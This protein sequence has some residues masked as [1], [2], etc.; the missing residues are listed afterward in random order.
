MATQYR[1]EESIKLWAEDD[2]PRE[3][4]I[5][6]GSSAL[7]DA[8]LLAI[9]L[10]SGSRTESALTLSKRLL[11]KYKDDLNE[12]A[13]AELEELKLFNGV[14]DAKAVSILSAME[15]SR[16]RM[17]QQRTKKSK[18]S[19]SRDAFEVFAPVLSDLPHEE[20]WVCYMNRANQILKLDQISKG[21][22]HGTVADSRL[23]FG[24]ALK[25]K[26]CALILAHNHPSGNLK[27]SEADLQ[28]TRRIKQA[29][30]LMEISLLDHLI[31]GDGDYFSFSDQGLI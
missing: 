30:D 6:K 10:G 19:S 26:A 25:L 21:G 18:L 4:L 22:I 5:L 28:L 9:L 31:I 12:L 3:K 13:Q 16:R 23:I 24:R 1:Q 7:S 29:G 2:R 27:A 17:G 11:R 20:F 14:G 8:E 15:L